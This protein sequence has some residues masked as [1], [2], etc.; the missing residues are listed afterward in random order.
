MLNYQRVNQ[1]PEIKE[2]KPLLLF[3]RHVSFISGLST[4]F[5]NLCCSAAAKKS[6][7]HWNQQ[8]KS[9]KQKPKKLCEGKWK[10]H[11]GNLQAIVKAQPWFAKPKFQSNLGGNG[12]YQYISGLRL[13]PNKDMHDMFEDATDSTDLPSGND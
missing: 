5:W 4:G 12:E 3:V 7:L 1:G 10:W 6:Q 2:N 11:V 13:H 8:R 9:H